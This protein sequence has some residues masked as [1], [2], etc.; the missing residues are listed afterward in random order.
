MGKQATDFICFI[1]IK[2][3]ALPPIKANYRF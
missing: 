3:S 1:A 2:R